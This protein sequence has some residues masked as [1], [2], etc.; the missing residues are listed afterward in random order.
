MRRGFSSN[1]D[2]TVPEK[3]RKQFLMKQGL[4]VLPILHF[5]M[6]NR[7]MFGLRGHP[8]QNIFY[9]LLFAA[10]PM[11][12]LPEK[13]RIDAV[14]PRSDKAMFGPYHELV[15]PQTL[16]LPHIK[17]RPF[18]IKVLPRG[19]IFP[20]IFLA[21]NRKGRGVHSPGIHPERGMSNIE[22]MVGIQG[23]HHVVY[24]ISLKGEIGGEAFHI[25][26]GTGNGKSSSGITEIVLGVYD[27]EESI[28]FHEY[29]VSFLLHGDNRKGL[30][31]EYHS[32][33]YFACFLKIFPDWPE[34]NKTKEPSCKRALSL[35]F[36]R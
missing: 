13:I 28:R 2:G 11:L 17:I 7:V 3:Q 25:S 1:V 23:N 15:L 35:D 24:T 12:Q 31:I 18:S 27:K 34:Q 4:L 8:L 36:F 19:A 9:L 14:P 20:K 22:G 26:L 5:R 16:Q 10:F 6:K 29:A 21:D 32:T 30:F 33:G